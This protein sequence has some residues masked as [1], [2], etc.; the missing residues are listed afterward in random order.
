VS[1]GWF[2]GSL[3]Q[4]RVEVVS[5][6]VLFPLAAHILWYESAETRDGIARWGRRRDVSPATV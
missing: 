5:L 2:V 1:G 3:L 6:I 4:G